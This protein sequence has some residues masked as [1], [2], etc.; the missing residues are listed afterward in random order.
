MALVMANRNPVAPNLDLILA[1]MKHGD[2]V[3]VNVTPAKGRLSD[4][5]DYLGQLGVSPGR[6]HVHHDA[7][8]PHISGVELSAAQV[9]ALG[10]RL[11]V[12]CIQKYK[13]G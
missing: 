5:M 4:V 12:E 10:Q 6:E 1:S 13:I 9:R 11:Y 7:P 8:T 2:K 3:A